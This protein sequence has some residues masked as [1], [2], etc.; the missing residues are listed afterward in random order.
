MSSHP[1]EC[2]MVE[3]TK[4]VARYL[5]RFTIGASSPCPFHLGGHTAEVRIEDGPE[6]PGRTPGHY[7]GSA[8]HDPSDPRWPAQCDC[9]YFFLNDDARQLSMYR[10]YVRAVPLDP[11][12]A[13]APF[14]L[15]EAPAGAMWYADWF[16]DIWKGPDGHCLMLKLPHGHEWVIDGPSTHSGPGWTRQGEPPR[17]TVTPSILVQSQLGDYHGWLRDG[18]L[19]DA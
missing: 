17:L 2:F 18:F 16:A 15:R 10:L 9:G 13:Q 19:V 5:R 8:E 11:S 7:A 3:P 1:I 12:V 14:T 6:V 4:T